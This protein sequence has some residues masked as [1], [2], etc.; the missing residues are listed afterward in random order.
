[1]DIESQFTGS[2][3]DVPILSKDQIDQMELPDMKQL[4]IRQFAT[5]SSLHLLCWNFADPTK[6]AAGLALLTE[7][8]SEPETRY[9]V[10]LMLRSLGRPTLD[11]YQG[12]VDSHGTVGKEGVDFV[13]ESGY[14]SHCELWIQCLPVIEEKVWLRLKQWVDGNQHGLAFRNFTDPIW[15]PYGSSLQT[16]TYYPKLDKE[17]IAKLPSK[18]IGG[19]VEADY[20]P[21]LLKLIWARAAIAIC[22]LLAANGRVRLLDVTNDLNVYKQ[23]IRES[24]TDFDPNLYGLPA[25]VGSIDPTRFGASHM[26]IH[27]L[28]S[29]DTKRGSLLNKYPVIRDP[30]EWSCLERMLLYMC[31]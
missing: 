16:A 26:T 21:W 8:L 11:T 10:L 14:M 29:I 3:S 15:R 28:Y 27:A 4:N 6:H 22:H 13:W 24:L 31:P 23:V 2:K 30:Y 12:A 9:S 20:I 18:Y 19:I 5:G 25:N 1:M 7:L 17:E